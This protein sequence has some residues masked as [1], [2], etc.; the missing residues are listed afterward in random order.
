MKLI[1]SGASGDLGRRITANLLQHLPASELILLTRNP[2]SLAQAAAQGADVRKADFSAT[3]TLSAAMQ[4][5]EVLLLIS[6]LSIGRRAEQH[7]NAI[8]AAQAAGVKH[9]VYTSSCGIQPQTPSISGQEHY[10]TEQILQ[11]SGLTFTILRNSWYADVTPQFLLPAALA[12]GS[13][14]AST[15]T[16]LVAPVAKTDC[17]RAAAAVLRNPRRH[18]NAIY[19]ITGPQLLTFA[20]IARICSEACGKPVQYTN[21]SHEEKLAIFDAMGVKRDYEEGMMNENT[22]AWASNEMITYEMAIKQQY[23]SICS[24]HVELITGKKALSLAEVIAMHA[25]QA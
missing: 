7:G 10:A 13:L 24:H 4:G 22:N 21:V 16:G 6:T 11:K 23:F 12:T 15:G 2:A 3:A 17:A 19:E 25:R 9:V 20:D 14:V 5:G 8:A 1:I 18:A